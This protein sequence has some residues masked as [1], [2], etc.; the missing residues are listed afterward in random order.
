MIDLKDVSFKYENLSIYNNLNLNFKK[1]IV[2]VLLGPSG[3]G[4]TTL[5]NL[6]SGVLHPTS[7][8]IKISTDLVISYLF[9]D[10]RL[11][12]WMSV[13]E[14]IN[15]VLD[16]LPQEIKKERIEHYINELELQS[17][18]NYLPSELSGG[19]RQ[20]VSLAR[21]FAY[22]SNILLMDEPFKGLDLALKVNLFKTFNR[23]CKEDKRSAILVT[24]D[25]HEAILL[26]DEIIVLS[27]RPVS[28]RQ[29]FTNSTPYKQRN[30]SNQQLLSLE[31]E[32]YRLIS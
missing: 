24:H 18:S 17:F 6:I 28:I 20:R 21:A 27:N 23:V 5:L 30:L 16:N 11:L 25:I 8:N 29:T 1:G 15:F 9:Q 2:T 4:K 12:P 7:G 19:M 3:C 32:L 14:N 31:K 22:P 13:E 10:P 26:G